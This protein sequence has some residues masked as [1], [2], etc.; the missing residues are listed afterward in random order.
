MVS[1]DITLGKIPTYNLEHCKVWTHPYPKVFD[2]NT[3]PAWAQVNWH[4]IGQ[5]F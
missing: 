5:F 1:H 4:L 2:E 3:E